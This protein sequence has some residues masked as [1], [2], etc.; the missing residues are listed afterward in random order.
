MKYS[1]LKSSPEYFYLYDSLFGH[2]PVYLNQNNEKTQ[3][4]LNKL[5]LV[6]ETDD[7][8]NLSPSIISN[9]NLI[10]IDNPVITWEHMVHVSFMTFNTNSHEISAQNLFT[11]SQILRNELIGKL[12]LVMKEFEKNSQLYKDVLSI[13][14]ESKV[15]LA[16][17]IMKVKYKYKFNFY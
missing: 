14:F 6:W 7:I 13:G 8:S 17:S 4:D 5:K 12:K 11:N 1:F 15:R 3:I 16:L 9:S 10:F 2:D